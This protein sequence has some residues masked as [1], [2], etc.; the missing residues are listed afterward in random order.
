MI[1]FHVPIFNI[2]LEIKIQV[3]SHSTVG[4]LT[5]CWQFI[6]EERNAPDMDMF[7]YKDLFLLVTWSYRP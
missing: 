3:R 2:K 7:L 6:P 1:L 4:I 5:W